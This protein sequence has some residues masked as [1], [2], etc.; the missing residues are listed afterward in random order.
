MVRLIVVVPV[1]V[2]YR[3]VLMLVNVGSG[4]LVL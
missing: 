3:L 4:P 2:L 1:R